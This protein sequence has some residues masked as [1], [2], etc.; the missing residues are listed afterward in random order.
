MSRR[1]APGNFA[2]T[3]AATIHFI[4]AIVCAAGVYAALTIWPD[5]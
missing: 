5:M 2:I 3:R 1:L 4:T